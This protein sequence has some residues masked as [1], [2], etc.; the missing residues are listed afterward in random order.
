MSDEAQAPGPGLAVSE[1]QAVSIDGILELLRKGRIKLEGLMPNSSNYTFLVTVKR[2]DLQ[3]LAIYKPQ[4]GERPLWDF[5]RGTLCLREYATFVVAMALGWV[6]VP[7]T[8]LRRGPHGIGALQLFVDALPDHNFFTLREQ[9]AHVFQRMCAFDYVVNN[10]D[11]K[12][13]HCL[14]G[15]DDRIWGID[16]GIALS[17]EFKLRTVIWDWAGEPLPS[18]IVADL[19]SLQQQLSSDSNVTT[20]LSKLLQPDEM[21]AL[22]QRLDALL[23]SSTFPEPDPDLPNIPWPLI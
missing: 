8:V 22:R 17:A 14:L 5:P 18:D 1:H 9:Y 21:D 2:R 13:G 10:A 12:G 20:V 7:P 4:K 16:H 11:R 19:S 3:C 15:S 6:F 23:R